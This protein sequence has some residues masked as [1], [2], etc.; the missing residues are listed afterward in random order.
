MAWGYVYQHYGAR[1]AYLVGACCALVNAATIAKLKMGPY[2]SVV[3]ERLP[4]VLP[5]VSAESAS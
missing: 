3:E 1:H 2:A 4:L 5:T